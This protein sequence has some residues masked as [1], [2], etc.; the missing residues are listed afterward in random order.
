MEELNERQYGVLS[1]IKLFMM[2]NG[3]SP[4]VRELCKVCN[5]KSTASIFDYL[6][7]LKDLGYIN[8]ADKKIR[9]IVIK[10]KGNEIFKMEH[11]Y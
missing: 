1:N 6:K 3:Y 10:E 8:Y 5:L 11:H 9:T 7:Q 2:K 4:S